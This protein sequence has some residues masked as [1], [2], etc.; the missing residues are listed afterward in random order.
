[1]Q[2]QTVDVPLIA[3]NQSWPATSGIAGRLL[4]LNNAIAK[5][6]RHGDGGS[7]LR[8]EKRDGFAPFAS[9]VRDTDGTISNKSLDGCSSLLSRGQQLVAS[10]DAF[11]FGQSRSDDEWFSPSYVQ[12]TNALVENAVT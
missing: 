8:V 5:R 6:W 9:D 3:L 4:T 2:S 11:L 10:A 12:P 1:M 7:M